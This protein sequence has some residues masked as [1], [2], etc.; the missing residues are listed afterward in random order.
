MTEAR[1]V[2]VEDGGRM[3]ADAFLRGWRGALELGAG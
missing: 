3:P 1:I 2:D